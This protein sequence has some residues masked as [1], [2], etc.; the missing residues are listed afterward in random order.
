MSER[1]LSP[2]Q[3]ERFEELVET[4]RSANKEA[5][6][7]VRSTGHNFEYERAKA[8]WYNAIDASLED[9]TGMG[10]GSMSETLEH[11]R[12]YEEDEDEN[13]ILGIV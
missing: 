3:A 10:N 6:N 9:F 4:I 1:R 7:M 11:L 12:P 13:E 8:Y 2:E 5:I